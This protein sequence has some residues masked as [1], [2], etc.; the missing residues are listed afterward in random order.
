[1]KLIKMII[2]SVGPKDFDLNHKWWLPWHVVHWDGKNDLFIC[3]YFNKST[4]MMSTKA[5]FS[6]ISV[7]FRIDLKPYQ[8]RTIVVDHRG[9]AFPSFDN[10]NNK[11]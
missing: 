9:E 1:M 4:A 2:T 7:T 10:D 5:L 6:L 8:L 11:K 3:I